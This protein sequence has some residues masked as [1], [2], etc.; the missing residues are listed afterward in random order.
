VG[1]KE[2]VEQLFEEHGLQPASGSNGHLDGYLIEPAIA[3]SLIVRRGLGVASAPPWR[4]Q[5]V[6][7]DECEEILLDAGIRV[8]R[9][10]AS[11]GGYLVIIDD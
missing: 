7:L 3:D 5:N 2:R 9:V 8:K 11:R 1:L 10:A 6:E 4:P